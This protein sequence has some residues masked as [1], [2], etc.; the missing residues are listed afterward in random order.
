[1]TEE[2][3]FISS[4]SGLICLSCEENVREALLFHKGILGVS[5]SYIKGVVDITYDPE[6]TGEDE[7][8]SMLLGCGYPVTDRVHPGLVYDLMTVI[9]V[10]AVYFLL[11]SIRLPHVPSLS[12]K[13]GGG[14]YLNVFLIGLVSGTHC[15]V[16]CGGLMLSS[17]RRGKNSVERF[18]DTVLYNLMRVAVSALL[19][20][21]FASLG[22]ALVF[23]VKARSMIYFTA[24]LY[25]IFSALGIWGVPVIRQLNAAF[26]EF[27][28]LKHKKT[29]LGPL[30][31]GALTAVMPCSLSGSMWMT[32]VTME[33]GSAGA[34]MMAIWAL[35]TV[36]AMLVFG[37]VS[38]IRKGRR[39]YGFKVR[40]N[41]VL[42]LTLG[43]RLT[44][45]GVSL[46]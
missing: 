35:G 41:I 21:L 12:G 43:L 22:K 9:A 32:A 24:G 34:L 30:L 28:T 14:F 7:I 44:L 25:V 42:L 16:M 40:L 4:L 5:V 20:F 1:M 19:G 3:H 26:P 17:I 37:M 10:A 31:L 38:G 39:F 11:Q 45:M 33:S 15:I 8:K 6:E 36:P 46:I 27:C 29:S 23:T 18:F 2:K 13:I